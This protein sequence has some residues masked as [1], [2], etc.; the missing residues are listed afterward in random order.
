MKTLTVLAIL[1]AVPVGFT[2]GEML[3]SDEPQP[4]QPPIVAAKPAIVAEQIKAQQFLAGPFNIDPCATTAL[5]AN[6]FVTIT[7]CKN[8]AL[9]GKKIPIQA[10]D[11]SLIDP[12]YFGKNVVW[13]GSMPVGSSTI[14][15]R[16]WAQNKAWWN[17]QVLRNG[18]SG[19]TAGQEGPAI[20]PICNPFDIPYRLNLLLEGI[21]ELHVTP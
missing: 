15:F 2:V 8:P 11:G 12:N 21:T 1:A 6:L 18:G 20:N 16:F 14:N 3:R 10:V 4:E 19:S 5:P 7:V 9:V 17:L 13:V